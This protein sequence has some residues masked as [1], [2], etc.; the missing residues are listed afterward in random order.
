LRYGNDVFLQQIWIDWTSRQTDTDREQFMVGLSGKVGKD[1]LYFSH[2]IM[3][4]HNAGPMIK[5]PDDQVR[6][7]GAAMARVGVNLSAYTFLDSLDIHAGGIIGYDRL[8][9]VYNWRTGKGFITGIHAEYR[10]FFVNNTFYSGEPLDIPYGD[11]F[12]TSNRYD[13]LEI[14]WTPL[15]YKGIAGK[16]IAR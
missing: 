2:H 16:F 8:R 3:L 12:Y 6:D 11:K 5:I 14:G 15:R 4:W 9:G 1:L 7:N 13:R 10:R